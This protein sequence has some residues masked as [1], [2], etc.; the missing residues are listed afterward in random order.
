MTASHMVNLYDRL[1]W[2]LPMVLHEAPETAETRHAHI[3]Q[4]LTCYVFIQL[5]HDQEG[6]NTVASC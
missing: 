6:W 1:K 5:T 2:I 4:I 3:Y